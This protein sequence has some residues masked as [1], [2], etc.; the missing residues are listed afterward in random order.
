M[1]LSDER[2][3]ERTLIRLQ[4][5]RELARERGSEI[6]RL[7][8]EITKLKGDAT[9]MRASLREWREATAATQEALDVANVLLERFESQRS[10]AQREHVHETTPGVTS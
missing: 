5:W 8:V 3:D 1:A 4:A 10:S 6:A 9:V 7:D 2:I